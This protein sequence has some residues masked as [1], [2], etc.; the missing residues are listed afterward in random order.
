MKRLHILGRKS[1]IIDE[2]QRKSTKHEEID[3]KQKKL[4]CF[5]YILKGKMYKAKTLKKPS[6][7][8]EDLTNPKL[9][10]KKGSI[11]FLGV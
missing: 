8:V 3:E 9:P 7:F 2:R 11:E 4:D 10:I 6:L 1:K 5:I